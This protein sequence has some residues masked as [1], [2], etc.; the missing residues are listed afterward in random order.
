MT[1]ITYNNAITGTW[2]SG[3]A[4]WG[5]LAGEVTYFNG[6]IAGTSEEFSAVYRGGVLNVSALPGS[7]SGGQFT[8]N[9]SLDSFTGWSLGVT[10]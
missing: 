10:E 6:I 5:P 8:F 2:Y 1:I 4:G 7:V 9:G 3:E